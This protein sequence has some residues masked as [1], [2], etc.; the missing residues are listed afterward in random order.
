MFRWFIL[1]ASLSLIVSASAFGQGC[2]V[3]FY[4]LPENGAPLTTVCQ[5]GTPIPDGRSIKI[6]WDADGD[7]PD[8]DD[9]LAQLCI[10]PPN[11]EEGPTGSVNINTMTFN[12][13]T[14][15]GAAGYFVPD[16]Y[17]TSAGDVPNPPRFYLRIYDTD[18]VTPLWTSV[19]Y[20]VAAGYHDYFIPQSDWTC[21]AG[22]P[23]CVVVDE[24]E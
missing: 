23:Q 12:G 6:M 24:S 5:G 15:V 7:G 8:A 17:F 19:V 20:V 14:Y 11:C 10:D 22:G 9:S 18:G 2:Q 16:Y 21:G 3:G 13:Q 4:Y 1:L